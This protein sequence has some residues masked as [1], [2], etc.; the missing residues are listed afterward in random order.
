M[1]LIRCPLSGARGQ[2]VDAALSVNEGEH[3]KREIPC[4][5]SPRSPLGS[6]LLMS[7]PAV[8]HQQW[9]QGV[10]RGML[11]VP[12]P[13]IPIHAS[14]LLRVRSFTYYARP[15]V[16]PRQT[17]PDW[18]RRCA[19]ATL[20]SVAVLECFRYRQVLLAQPLVRVVSGGR[21]S[22]SGSRPAREMGSFAMERNVFHQRHASLCLRRT[23]CSPWLGRAN[24]HAVLCYHDSP[25][26]GGHPNQPLIKRTRTST[27]ESVTNPITFG[28]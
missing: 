14:A 12:P 2:Y 6:I 7:G 28:I 24:F 11:H 27:P 22:V 21:P 18:Y 10:K 25:S 19:S 3:V 9:Q 13:Q 26:R 23:I 16:L 20:L 1:N 17:P 5:V 8:Y 4:V 15:A